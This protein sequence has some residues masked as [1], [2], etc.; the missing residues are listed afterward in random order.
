[1]TLKGEDVKR[2]LGPVDETTLAEIIATGASTSELAQAWTWLNNEEAMIGDGRPLP[3]G[4]VA[5]LIEVLSP[6]LIDPDEG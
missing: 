3:S 6:D 4:R 1:M 5:E 2:I